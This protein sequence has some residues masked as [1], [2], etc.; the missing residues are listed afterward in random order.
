M[1]G[2]LVICDEKLRFN[3][4]SA[5]NKVKCYRLSFL[6]KEKVLSCSH[7]VCLRPTEQGLMGVGVCFGLQKGLMGVVVYL[8]SSSILS[9]VSRYSLHRLEKRHMVAPSM[10]R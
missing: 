6:Q 2:L 1:M 5:M 7:W 10:M 9:G 3:D 4:A 8:S